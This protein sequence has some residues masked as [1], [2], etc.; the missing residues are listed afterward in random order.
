M[1]LDDALIVSQEPAPDLVALDDALTALER[2]D[3]RKT[4]VVELRFF[5]GLASR[6]PP[7]PSVFQAT[8]SCATGGWPR[9]GWC[10]RWAEKKPT[11]YARERPVSW[12]PLAAL[13]RVRIMPLPVV[14]EFVPHHADSGYHTRIG[15]APPTGASPSEMIRSA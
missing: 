7:R 2:F 15:G 4:Q 12:C 3:A 5:A 13:P 11:D 6:R 14:D 10:A 1:T 8:P 9:H